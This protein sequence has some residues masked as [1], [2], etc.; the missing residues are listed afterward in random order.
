MFQT[1]AF[2]R[3]Y[4]HVWINACSGSSAT[5]FSFYFMLLIFQPIRLVKRKMA[6]VNVAWIYLCLCNL[7]LRHCCYFRL[8]YAAC[9]IHTEEMR[10]GTRQ[11][12]HMTTQESQT[13][14]DS[15]VLLLYLSHVTSVSVM[16]YSPLFNVFFWKYA[17][18]YK[19]NQCW[20]V[21]I[22]SVGHEC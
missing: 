6:L 4:L 2:P 21:V 13:D 7:R 22:N 8:F 15:V 19:S 9:R 3:L 18:C 1:T 16:F 11:S 14:V 10:P 5:S 20:F 12:P 17:V